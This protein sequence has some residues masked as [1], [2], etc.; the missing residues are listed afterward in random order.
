MTVVHRLVATIGR[1]DYLSP[2]HHSS[3]KVLTDSLGLNQILNEKKK[4]EALK[5]KKDVQE[6][7]D[8]VK[9]LCGAS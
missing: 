5:G 1:L 4:L 9:N 3:L 8:E 2:F 6:L 7:C